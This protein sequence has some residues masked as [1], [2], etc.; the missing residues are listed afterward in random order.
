MS[1]MTKSGFYVC[2]RCFAPG[3]EN[4]FLGSTSVQGICIRCGG[5]AAWLVD[6]AINDP[7]LAVKGRSATFL[8]SLALE[9]FPSLVWDVN[10]YY[11]EL[12]VSPW[13]SRLEIRQ[14]YQR[15][16]GWKSSRLT[17][18]VK[19]LLNDEIR[20][21]YD[22]V[23]L[24][25]VFFDRYIEASVRREMERAAFQERNENPDVETEPINLDDSLNK[26]FDVVDKPGRPEQYGEVGWGYYL[27]ASTCRNVERLD[28]W[29]RALA[30]EFGRKGKVVKLAVGYMSTPGWSVEEVDGQIVA[31]LGESDDPSPLYAQAVQEHLNT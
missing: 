14:A 18:I 22:S 27:W 5:L 19:Q 9:P 13:A 24:G 7:H 8:T 1:T 30:D 10:G 29:R 28:E 3:D 12:G 17:Y 21:A 15:K 16:A 11:A 25:S 31:F 20:L 23:E 2:G 26:S 6:S 4:F